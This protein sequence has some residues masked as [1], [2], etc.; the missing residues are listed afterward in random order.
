VRVGWGEAGAAIRQLGRDARA[1]GLDIVVDW[2]RGK[3]GHCIVR[4]GGRFTVIKSGE[5][6]PLMEKI[7]RK[8][9]GLVARD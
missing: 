8:Q 3:G 5:I 6:T 4:V 9:I 7:I 1:A 2:A